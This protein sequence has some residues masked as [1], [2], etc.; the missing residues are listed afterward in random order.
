MSPIP[1][2]PSVSWR[3]R[4]GGCAVLFGV[5]ITLS[6]CAAP[7]PEPVS[8]VTK[9]QAY[10]S[11]GG[12]FSME[13]PAD[14]AVSERGGAGGYET[15]FA[16]SRNNRIVVAQQMLPGGIEARLLRDDTRDDALISTVQAHYNMLE[17]QF[18]SFHGDAPAPGTIINMFAASGGFTCQ[19]KGGFMRPEAKLKGRT[20]VL[21]GLDNLYVIDAFG[22]A[23][24]WG[25]VEPAF[26]HVVST[27][28]HQ[29]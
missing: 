9:W 19:T 25:A 29:E 12:A 10:R 2:R 8:P 22:D 4:L 23:K 26:D 17:R 7:T 1:D 15:S 11:G 28:K 6:S 3:A 20:V 14:W 18:T 27:F 21:I 24:S 16:A 5:A 13:A